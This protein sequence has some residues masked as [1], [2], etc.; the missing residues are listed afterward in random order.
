M[1]SVALGV[2]DAETDLIAFPS[3]G[4][5]H[6]RRQQDRALE[7]D[8]DRARVRDLGT[9][10]RQAAGLGPHAVGD[11][12]LEAE[13]ARRQRVDVNRVEVLGY[14]RIPPAE[15][16][17][18]APG[19]G[20]GQLGAR[21]RA[22]RRRRVGVTAA[23]TEV[24]RDLLPDEL[25]PDARLRADRELD[26][27]WVRLAGRRP[28]PQRQPL[29][30]ADRAVLDDPVGDVNEADRRKREA[31]VGHQRQVQPER[32]HVGVG[33]RQRVADREPAHALVGHEP[34]AVDLGPVE[35]QR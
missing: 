25:G 23:A 11:R 33:R 29:A 27:A 31:A 18:Q 15:V 20:R 34:V 10:R 8:L 19:R 22:R 4:E 21:R 1:R 26:A 24:G 9:E 5:L 2:A 12:R 35:R 6:R 30:R 13:R 3:L 32:Q 28:D 16:A 14:R 7:R 17:A